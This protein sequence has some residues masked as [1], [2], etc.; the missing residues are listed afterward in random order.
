VPGRDAE[1]MAWFSTLWL[2]GLCVDADEIIDY[3]GAVTLI[4]VIVA[5]VVGF[6][7]W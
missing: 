7:W 2:I 1:H 6:V 5:I 4:I 3:V